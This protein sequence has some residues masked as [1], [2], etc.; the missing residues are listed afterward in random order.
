M[1]QSGLDTRL[2]ES[3][4]F[5]PGIDWPSG[6][7]GRILWE[8]PANMNVDIRPCASL[9][10]VRHALAPIRYYFGRSAPDQDQA[11]RF[12]RVLPVERM[13]AAWEGSRVVGGLG[14]FPFDLTVP[15]GRV[16]AAGVTVAGVLPTQRRRGLLRAMMRALLDACD[17]RGE[18]VAYLW[19]TEDTIY[20][21]FGFGLASFTAEIDLPRER[22][23]FHTSFAPW[24]RVQLVPPT[25]AEELL[26]PIYERVAI[27][28]PGMFARSSTW[29][30]ARTLDDPEWRRGSNGDLQCA[31]VEHRGRPAA[32][33]IYRM[34]SSFE[35]GLQAGSV[36]VIEAVGDSPE[37]T[38]AIWRYLLD[39]DWMARVKAWLLPVD[40]P[41]LFLLAEPRRLGFSLHDGVWVRLLDIET[42]LSARA[43][44]PDGSVVIEVIDE[45]CPRNAGC[46][47]VSAAGVERT[48]ETP[49]LRCDIGGLGSVYLGGF[50]WTQLARA[51]RVQELIPGAIA[52]ADTLFQVTTAPWCPEIF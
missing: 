32:Y 7:A 46:W 13:Y 9:D 38:R 15:G 36:G 18:P 25:T 23:A 4:A 30:Q 33:A 50:K 17:Q 8:M 49:G 44:Q 19:A 52:R 43:Y 48:D 5:K 45:F 34:N 20:G 3:L 39:I 42:A 47:Q 14:A 51:L 37:A 27:E 6:L 12:A 10:E 1:N 31:V 40:H 29:W 41:L 35:R 16:P 11:E 28:T 2:R 21:R 24:G 26:A 22:S